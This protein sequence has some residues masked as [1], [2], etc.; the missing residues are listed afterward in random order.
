MFP[1]MKQEIDWARLKRPDDVAY[2][3]VF[4]TIRERGCGHFLHGVA[5]EEFEGRLA[6]CFAFNEGDENSVTERLMVCWSPDGGH[7]WT[8]PNGSAFPRSHADSHSVFLVLRR[9]TLVLWPPVLW[10]GRAAFDRKGQAGHPFSGFA[11]AGL[12]V[13]P[14]GMAGNG[15]CGRG[16]LAAGPAGAHGGREL[17]DPGL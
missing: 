16:F 15:R 6:V 2:Y 12:A 7:S 14:G 10:A 11:H 3:R 4:D 5:V 17:L 1:L 13:R 8:R 9:R